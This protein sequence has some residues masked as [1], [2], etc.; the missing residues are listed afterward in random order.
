[1]AITPI[2]FAP[3]S[4]LLSLSPSLSPP[5]RLAV[6]V[7][8]RYRPRLAIAPVSVSLSLSAIPVAVAPW[9]LI[10]HQLAN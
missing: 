8:D 3:V 4:V 9:T 7:G 1:M 2:A 6:A 10:R 5:I